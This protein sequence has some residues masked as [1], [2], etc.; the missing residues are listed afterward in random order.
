MRTSETLGLA[1]TLAD[2][3]LTVF[4][5][6]R[7]EIARWRQIAETIPD[8]DLRG[9]ALATL[10][11]ES[12][13]A[14]GAAIFATLAPR[15]HRDALVRLLVAWQV[16]Y[17]LLDTLDERPGGERDAFV[18]LV[19]ALDPRVGY[20]SL[21]DD[22]G[23]LDRLVA[24]C[25]A[26]GAE[27]PSIARVR[28][29]AV[30]AVRR[31]IE[32][33][34]RTHAVTQHGNDALRRWA[35]AQPEAEGY[36]WWEVAAGAISSLA[37]HAV[38]ATAAHPRTTI[39]VAGTVDAAYF[40][41]ICALSTLLDSTVD[42]EADA[43][44]ANHRCLAYYDGPAQ[45]LQRLV[46]IARIAEQAARALPGGRRHA[47]ILA[48]MTAF[49]AAAGGVEQER[50]HRQVAEALGIWTAPILWTLR[51][52]EQAKRRMAQRGPPGAPVIRGAIDRSSS[53]RQ[54]RRA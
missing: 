22:G 27:L 2:Y 25:R 14:E 11:E 47:V 19:A 4:P 34:E 15:G 45:T 16:A 42:T 13:L 9:L 35:R 37:V 17:D 32:G 46:A 21:A 40:P 43:G 12:G 50:V 23:Y 53:E 1:S 33:Q 28:A 36:L 10:E 48:G 18:A 24:C 7:R 29:V 49:Y 26:S 41:S 44:T 3:W 5:Q 39:D 38:L 51:L 30:R 6:A 54:R 20:T 31:C 8:D 52:R